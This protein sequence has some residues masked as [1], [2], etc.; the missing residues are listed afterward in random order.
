MEKKEEA[1]IPVEKMAGKEMDLITLGKELIK[2]NIN[3]L[4]HI[5]R[6]E[7]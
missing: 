2:K 6:D 1:K 7:N 4:I 5:R 3:G